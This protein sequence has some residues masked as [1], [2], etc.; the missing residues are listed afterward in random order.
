MCLS[1]QK[2]TVEAWLKTVVIWKQPG[3]CTSGGTSTRENGERCVPLLLSPLLSLPSAAA[4]CC[5]SLASSD[6]DIHEEGVRALYQSLE[7]VLLGL[8]LG[9]RVEKVVIDLKHT[10]EQPESRGGSDSCDTPASKA[11]QTSAR[12]AALRQ[13][14]RGAV[15]EGSAAWEAKAASVCMSCVEFVPAWLFGCSTQGTTSGDAGRAL[16][17]K[18]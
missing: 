1:H 8:K 16:S 5:S 7:L 12:R 17:R 15:G 10:A 11:R 2:T 6:L 3:H 13:P 4:S 18:P 9:R 14:R